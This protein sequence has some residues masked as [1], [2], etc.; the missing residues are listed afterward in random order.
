MLPSNNYNKIENKIAVASNISWAYLYSPNTQS[1]CW[2][3]TF[4]RSLRFYILC[5]KAQVI[6]RVTNHLFTFSLPTSGNDTPCVSALDCE[7]NSLASKQ[8]QRFL[9]LVNR[10]Q[11][12]VKIFYF[13]EPDPRA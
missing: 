8:E 7:W 11:L 10:E 5:L 4:S 9:G 13:L 12:E 1:K 3:V 2:F 6:A